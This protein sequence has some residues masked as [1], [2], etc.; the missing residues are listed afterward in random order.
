VRR[1]SAVV[2]PVAATTSTRAMR[3]SVSGARLVEHDGVDGVGALEHLAA[4]DDDP[5]LGA[6]PVPTMIAV[7]VASPSAQ[8]QAMMSTATAAVKASSASCPV[9][10]HPARVARR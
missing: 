2:D 5:E 10:S 1:T 3:P 7:G 4:L 8:G 9:S 6:R